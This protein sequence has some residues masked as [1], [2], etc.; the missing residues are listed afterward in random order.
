MQKKNPLAL[1]ESEVNLKTYTGQAIKVLGA[2]PL[3]AN[4]KGQEKGLLLSVVDGEG[5]N[6]LGS[7]LLIAFEV[8][9]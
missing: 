3:T 8:T 2:V 1:Q 6:L 5:P 4:F 9:L 7:D